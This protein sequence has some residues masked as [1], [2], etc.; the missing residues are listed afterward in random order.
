[1]G[2][3]VRRWNLMEE[4]AQRLQ[5]LETQ[6]GQQ[7]AVIEHRQEQLMRQQTTIDAQRAARTS[8]NPAQDARINLVV[9]RVGNKPETFAG[10]TH[11]RKGWSFKMRQYIA[12]VDEELY[13]ELVNV[14]AN[15]LREMPL[16]IMN[17]PQ[18]RRARH[19]AFMLTMHTKDRALQMSTKLSDPANGSEIWTFSGRVGAGTQRTVRSDADAVVAV[20]VCG[21]QRSSLGGVGTTCATV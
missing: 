7:R 3:V 9:L 14:E 18:K 5:Q 13:L 11:E 6:V 10:E 4:L 12:A 16:A 17:E 20:S 19:S 21:R 8:E 2:T 15:P 1:M